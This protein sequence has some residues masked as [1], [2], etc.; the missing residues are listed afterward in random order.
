MFTEE[1]LLPLGFSFC[2]DSDKL[3][4][5]C[6]EIITSSM[7]ASVLDLQKSVMQKVEQNDLLSLKA[8]CELFLGRTLDKTEQI[9]DWVSPQE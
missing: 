6:A 2:H 9:S 8:S 3:K 1:E 5:I 7:Q 4:S